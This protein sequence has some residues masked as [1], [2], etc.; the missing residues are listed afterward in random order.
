MQIKNVTKDNAYAFIS[1][2][3]TGYENF[4]FKHFNDI[5][6]RLTKLG[7]KHINP[8]SIC[9]KYK[10]DEVINNKDVFNKMV[11]EQQ[12]A[13]KECNILVLLKGWENSSGVR[14]ELKTAIDLRMKIVLEDDID[15]LF[16]KCAIAL[17]E[18]HD[19]D[20]KTQYARKYPNIPAGAKVKILQE[21]YVNFYGG[22]WTRVEWNGNWY[23][24]NPS[25]LMKI[26]V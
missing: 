24:V 8:V 7:I 17:C 20:W 16:E 14:L 18:L 25:K 2:P 23:W 26:D 21:D 10:K 3:M 6:D 12:I 13:E 22:P 5:S 4:N 15:M 11:E 19:E 9:K 1:G